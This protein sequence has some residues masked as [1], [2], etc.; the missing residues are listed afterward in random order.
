MKKKKKKKKNSGRSALCAGERQD[1]D[2]RHHTTRF[3]SA[4]VFHLQDTRPTGGMPHA[5][6]IS[7]RKTRRSPINKKRMIAVSKK[8]LHPPTA[9]PMDRELL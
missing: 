4:V 5:R 3:I 2:H 7:T 9:A 6:G 8:E 1:G